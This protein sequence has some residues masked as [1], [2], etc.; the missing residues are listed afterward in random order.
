VERVHPAQ[1]ISSLFTKQKDRGLSCRVGHIFSLHPTLLTCEPQATGR[2][3]YE[4]DID[5][6]LTPMELSPKTRT[7]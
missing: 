1:T 4:E 5:Y 6:N 3:N 7:M 2:P